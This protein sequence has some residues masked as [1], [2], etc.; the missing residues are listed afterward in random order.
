MSV[1]GSRRSDILPRRR[2][3]LCTGTEDAVDVGALLAVILCPLR[4]VLV[5]PEACPVE[6]ETREHDRSG[7]GVN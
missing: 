5:R 1:G 7:R 4:L 2:T 6:R 3:D